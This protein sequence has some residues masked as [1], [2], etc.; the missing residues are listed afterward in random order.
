MS[1]NIMLFILRR[2]TPPPTNFQ[3][4]LVCG[5]YVTHVQ[6]RNFFFCI[7]CRPI[8]NYLVDIEVNTPRIYW[9]FIKLIPE[10]HNLVNKYRYFK[11]VE[12][13]HVQNLLREREIVSKNSFSVNQHTCK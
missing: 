12:Q 10:L 2:S 1:R 6:I 7:L 13:S 9:H 3:N 11:H 5:N 8:N 4:K